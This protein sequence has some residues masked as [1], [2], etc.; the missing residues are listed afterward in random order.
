[1]INDKMDE[2]EE[3]RGKKRLG[4]PPPDEIF[5]L[6]LFCDIAYILIHL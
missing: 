4:G 2:R 3:G 5:S 1:M 6:L